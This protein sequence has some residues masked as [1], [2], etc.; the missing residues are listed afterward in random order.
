MNAVAEPCTLITV[1]RC[2]KCGGEVRVGVPRH[3]TVTTV[4]RESTPSGDAHCRV[5]E[6]EAGHPVRFAF[7][8]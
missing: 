4:P 3:A 2:G 6:C 5:T 1:I 7:R 8:S